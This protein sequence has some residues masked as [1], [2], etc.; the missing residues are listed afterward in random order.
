M[1][2]YSELLELARRDQQMK[3]DS[4]SSS[5]S[6]MMRDG[7]LRD[8]LYGNRRSPSVNLP[9]NFSIDPRFLGGE[10]PT[11]V[12]VANTPPLV[13]RQPPPPKPATMRFNGYDF[14]IKTPERPDNSQFAWVT[15]RDNFKGSWQPIGTPIKEEHVG[16]SVFNNLGEGQVYGPE[17]HGL[18]SP[19]ESTMT[20]EQLSRKLSD[21]NL[22][23]E[24]SREELFARNMRV[25]HHPTIMKNFAGG[26]SPNE[27]EVSDI[28]GEKK[29][30]SLKDLGKLR[31]LRNQAGYYE[32]TP[33]PKP[34]TPRPPSNVQ[35]IFSP[36]TPGSLPERL[37]AQSSAEG[38]VAAEEGAVAGG[39]A[40]GEAGMLG[41]ASAMAGRA[42]PILNL[43]LLGKM[44]MDGMNS[45]KQ[46]RKQQQQDLSMRT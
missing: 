5:S 12:S 7:S 30:F 35:N 24:G 21:L 43:V 14:P 25:K 38:A 9:Q 45:G 10:E 37:G 29:D 34:F 28:M 17:H 11:S 19:Q 4:V 8:E 23:S 32:N 18:N 13:L 27:A 33:A 31:D 20:D 39:A 6:S 36:R 22:P 42:V 26:K 16:K 44:L 46:D 15:N 40:A 41:G 3:K 1:S 2:I